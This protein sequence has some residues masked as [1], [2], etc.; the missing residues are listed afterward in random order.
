MAKATGKGLSWFAMRA[1]NGVGSINIFGDIG[2]YNVNF[3]DFAR[4]LDQLGIGADGELKVQI[5]SD[6]GDVYQGFAIYQALAMHP[7]TKTITVMGIAASMASVV[8]MA[9]D[10]RIMPKNATLMIHNPVGQIAGESDEIISFGEAVGEM[11]QNIAT[12]YSDASGGKLSVSKALALMDNQT[13]IGA[14]RAVALG[15]AT[16]VANPVK[17][18]AKITSRWKNSANPKG[19]PMSKN[20]A[21]AAGDLPNFEGVDDE[22]H[23]A[24]TKDARESLLAQQKEVRALCSVAGLSA[25][26]ANELN[27]K[28]LTVAEAVAELDKRKKDGTLK[29][30]PVAGQRARTNTGRAVASQNADAETINA[31]HAVDTEADEGL[32]RAAD[33]N[34]IKIWDRWNRTGEFSP[35]RARH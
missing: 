6:G 35:S 7:A 25:E 9:G 26:I 17:I 27:D 32:P 10:S 11:R 2:G 33:L 30:P 13:W 3:Q 4:Q 1:S 20:R 18:A 5:N 12:A 23:A 24:I 15:L 29:T 8:F 34:P 19:T 21:S 14:E 31:R 16:E 22:I 28:G